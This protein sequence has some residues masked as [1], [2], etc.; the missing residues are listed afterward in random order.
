MNPGD[1]PLHVVAT[2]GHVDHGKSALILRLTGMDPDRLAEEK[3]RGLT[4]DLGFAWTTLPSGREVGFVD[5][6]GHE[7]FIRNMLAGV[8]PVRLVLFVVAADEGWKPQSEEHLQI[9][10]VLGAEGA[11]VALTKRDLVDE[12]ALDAR[13]EQVRRRLDGTRLSG[14]SIV[15]CSSQTG[16]GVEDLRSAL[17]EMVAAAPAPARG[18]RPRQF[19]DRVFTIRGSGTVVT[20]TLTGGD[21]EK[22]AEVEVLPTGHRARIR[23][24]QTHHR[25]IDRARPV[26]RVA[27]NLAGTAKEDLERGDV[28]V[29]P[30]QWRPTTTFEAF[31]EPVRR[32]THSVTSRGAFKLYAGSAERDARVRFY[33]DAR[34]LE[35]AGTYARISVRRSLILD[36][37][38]RF[39]LREAGRR[40]TVAGGRVV[41]AHPPS[42]AGSDA[43]ARLRA[44]DDAAPAEVP[45]VLLEWGRILP[46]A[47]LLFAAGALPDTGAVTVGAWLLSESAAVEAQQRVTRAL[48]AHHAEHP[49]RPG[50]ELSALRGTLAGYHAA[51]LDPAPADAFVAHLASAGVVIREATAVRLP[52][53]RVTTAGSEDADRLV[54]AVTADETAPPTVRELTAAGYDLELI[55]AVCAEGRLVRVA[56]DLVMTPSIVEGALELIR[57]AGPNGM[58]VSDVRQALGTSRKYAVPLLEHLD[59][60]GL[61]RRVGDVRVARG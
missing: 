31:V 32:L 59:A 61:T 23:G 50:M 33:T 7:R 37:N 4:I 22:G 43:T 11:V 56:P 13:F 2:A 27:V 34:G 36:R 9:V 29:L 48:A 42:R 38:E 17:E 39:V 15:A 28:L 45:R 14:A 16:E 10:D 24:L 49:L 46:A 3:R 25:A 51:F 26:S 19:I 60:R 5:V 52:T 54:S 35:A 8:G 6:P 53:H 57:T 18:G 41:D 58:T 20:G 1:S 47:D 21:L 40:E 44:L 30:G 12:A 55:A